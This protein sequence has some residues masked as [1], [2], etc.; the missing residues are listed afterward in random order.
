MGAGWNSCV[1]QPASRQGENIAFRLKS[2]TTERGFH[3][4]SGCSPARVQIDKGLS[5]LLR[6]GRADHRQ[7]PD[8]SCAKEACE[9]EGVSRFLGQDRGRGGPSLE[10]FPRSQANAQGC[11][12]RWKLRGFR[13]QEQRGQIDILH[14]LR[15]GNSYGVGGVDP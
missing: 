11:G 7:T 10:Q 12:P 3:G 2:Y 1:P 6:F 4:K 15:D 8:S 13:Y 5:K 14:K 9:L